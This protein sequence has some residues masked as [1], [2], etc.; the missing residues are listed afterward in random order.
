MRVDPF[1]IPIFVDTVDL[2]KIE[3]S[4]TEYHPTFLS[5][6]QS[7]Y[8]SSPQIHPDTN[9]YLVDIIDRHL[10]TT[11]KFKNAAIM[12]M[13]RNVYKKE[14][15]QEVHIHSNS[16]WSFIIYETVEN[17]R[18]VFLNPAWKMVETFYS[19]KTET[20][21][22]TWRP[23]V[24]PGTIIIFPS[25]IEHYVLAGNEGSTIAGNIWL[26]YVNE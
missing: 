25:F 12:N 8:G 3:I 24:G 5:E 2:S 9:D 1:S 19:D 6:V 21:P 7:N 18:T 11:G 13:W 15:T 14:D 10:S 26:E 20:F 16:K 17:S 4:E 23:K 22:I